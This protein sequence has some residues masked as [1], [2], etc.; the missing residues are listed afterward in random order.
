MPAAPTHCTFCDLVQGAGEVSICY[1]DA[2][3][4]AFM[5]IQPVNPGHTLV[6]PRQHY[7]SLVD[8]PHDVAM[9]LFEVSMRLGP[10]VRKV[11]GAEGMNIVVNS[12]AAAGQDVFHYHVHVIPRKAGDGFDV[13]LPFDGSEMPERERLDATA[14]RIIAAMR[15]PM[16]ATPH[17][18]SRSPLAGGV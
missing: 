1:E 12:G 6:V 14:A 3:T 7:E 18:T 13:P 4:I 5:D 2:I 10:V 15:D 9:H 17:S 11:S 8:I 16:R